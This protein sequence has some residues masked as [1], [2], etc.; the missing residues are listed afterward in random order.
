V[1]EAALLFTVEKTAVIMIFS[2]PL[3]QPVPQD[4]A[5]AAGKVRV[6]AIQ[7]ALPRLK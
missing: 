1:D 5:E 2:G 7:A 3:D 4:F 6:T